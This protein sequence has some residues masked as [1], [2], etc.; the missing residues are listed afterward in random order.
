MTKLKGPLFSVGAHGTLGDVLTFQGGAS[1]PHVG[2]VPRHRDAGS[3]GQLSQRALFLAAVA[4][5]NGLSA[6]AKA[7][8]NAIA[9]G[10]RLTGYQYALKVFMLGAEAPAVGR[11]FSDGFSLGFG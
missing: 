5:W 11:A 6:G 2:K 4:N 1:G 3:G 9:A 8:Y 10:M 7:A